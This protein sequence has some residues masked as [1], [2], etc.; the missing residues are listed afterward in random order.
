M[1]CCGS[2]RPVEAI[3]SFPILPI[4]EL[5]EAITRE[6]L[7]EAALDYLARY[8]VSTSRLRWVLERRVRRR[9]A[10]R[11]IQEAARRVIT[12]G[13]ATLTAQGLLEDGRYALARA[14]S[15]TRQGRSRRWIVAK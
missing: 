2:C 14:E 3:P 10:D 7:H 4:S 6:A 5:M 13:I 15:L 9:T 8:M 11:G 12:E 1:A